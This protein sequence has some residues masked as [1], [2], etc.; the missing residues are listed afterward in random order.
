MK[1]I[2]N[3]LSSLRFVG[4][5]CLLFCNRAGTVFWI[6][7]ALCGISDMLD[8]YLARKLNAET[9]VG[10][11]L[12]SMADLCFVVCSATCLVPIL[13]IPTWLWIWAGV[14]V[15]IKLTNQ[16]S[17]L[18]INHRLCFPHTRANKLTGLLLFAAVPMAFWS[19]IPVSVVAGAATFAAIHEGHCIRSQKKNTTA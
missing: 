5:A 14:I 13:H 18:V 8:G 1:R 12:D 6:L 2:P 17:A 10:V 16:I 11:V 4:A 7:Y 15:V 19:M 9:K 3:I